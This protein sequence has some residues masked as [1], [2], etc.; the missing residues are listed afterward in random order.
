MYWHLRATDCSPR[1]LKKY[2]IWS[3]ASYGFF[4]SFFFTLASAVSSQDAKVSQNQE[5]P[6]KKRNSAAG[7]CHFFN[8]KGL[9]PKYF[10]RPTITLKSQRKSRKFYIQKFWKVEEFRNP[11]KLVPSL[12][13]KRPSHRT[14][15]HRKQSTSLK[16]RTNTCFRLIFF[17]NEFS[18]LFLNRINFQTCTIRWNLEDAPSCSMTGARS[19]SDAGR[20]LTTATKQHAKM[21][22]YV[23]FMLTRWHSTR[24]WSERTRGCCVEDGLPATE[25]KNAFPALIS[26]VHRVEKRSRRARFAD[27]ARLLPR[28]LSSVFLPRFS[29]LRKF[30]KNPAFFWKKVSGWF[31]P[32]FGF[33]LT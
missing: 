31:W 12:V 21:T 22:G 27:A 15:M 16:A 1:N 19:D 33:F 24:N 25:G 32:S 5:K 8:I 13:V 10:S 2:L 20:A 30:E 17:S 3:L 14:L 18:N 6:W 9:C 23:E 4:C 11:R 7:T 28:I 29:F 26:Q